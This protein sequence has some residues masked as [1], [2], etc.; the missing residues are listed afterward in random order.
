[1]VTSKLVTTG[2][3]AGIRMLAIAFFL[4]LVHMLV[5]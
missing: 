4:D 1:M 2:M 3:A 5:F